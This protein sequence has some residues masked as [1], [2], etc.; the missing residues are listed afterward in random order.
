MSNECKTM[1]TGFNEGYPR[2]LFQG[3]ERG[4]GRGKL[5]NK[6][7]IYYMYVPHICAVG[8]A[9]DILRPLHSLLPFW[10]VPGLDF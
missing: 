6:I 3:R 5:V 7:D 8:L 2:Q 1:L 9:F 4:K 10:H